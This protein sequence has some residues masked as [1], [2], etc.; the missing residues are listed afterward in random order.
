MTKE[1]AQIEIDLLKEVI[2]A[3]CKKDYTYLVYGQNTYLN[4]VACALATRQFNC[5]CPPKKE[6]IPTLTDKNIAKFNAYNPSQDQD[7]QILQ[8]ANDK[9]ASDVKRP[10]IQEKFIAG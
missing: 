2:S 6:H 1:Q 3:I 9:V 10:S 4:T 7:E 8:E 5:L